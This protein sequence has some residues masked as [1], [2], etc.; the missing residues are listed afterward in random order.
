MLKIPS[1]QYASHRSVAI[2]CRIVRS[3]QAP[4]VKVQGLLKCFFESNRY[5][6]L[7]FGPCCFGLRFRSVRQAG[8]LRTLH[9]PNANTKSTEPA[10][11]FLIVSR[12]QGP[13]AA[14]T[15][16]CPAGKTP[17]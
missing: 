8:L 17:P 11:A 3:R 9:I 13:F 2:H 4:H 12:R 1:M 5:W 15:A 16:A 14:L 6:A 7:P 10:L